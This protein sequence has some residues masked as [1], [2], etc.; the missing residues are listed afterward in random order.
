MLKHINVKVVTDQIFNDLYATAREEV[1]K[2]TTDYN[3]FK[4]VLEGKINIPENDSQYKEKMTK[5][6][7]ENMDRFI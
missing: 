6:W 7:Q 2:D 1:L 4:R 3:V 5:F